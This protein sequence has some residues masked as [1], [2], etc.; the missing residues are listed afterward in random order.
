MRK[1]RRLLQL[2]IFTPFFFVLITEIHI[3]SILSKSLILFPLID[4][5]V[6]FASSQSSTPSL[7]IVDPCLSLPLVM[8]P[9]HQSCC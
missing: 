4:A 1:F 5:M 8:S 7:P 6:A 9:S 3:S 2:L